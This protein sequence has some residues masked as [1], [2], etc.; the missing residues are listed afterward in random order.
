MPTSAVSSGF[1]P[2][3]NAPPGVVGSTGGLGMGFSVN[4]GTFGTVGTTSGSTPGVLGNPPTVTST[5]DGGHFG[6]MYGENPG[7]LGDGGGY[8]GPFGLD[9]GSDTANS[10]AHFVSDFGIIPMV[11]NMIAELGPQNAIV[12]PDAQKGLATLMPSTNYGTLPPTP[13]AGLLQTIS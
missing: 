8:M 3:S 13:P 7:L 12:I 1:S 4:P 2:S 9:F 6:F 11:L 5:A 10:L